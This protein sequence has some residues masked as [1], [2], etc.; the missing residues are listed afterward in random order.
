MRL[1]L[2]LV[3]MF[4]MKMCES[5]ILN[6]SSD[7]S[8]N[9]GLV[10]PKPLVSH[11]RCDACRYIALVI[12]SNLRTADARLD[13]VEE[14]NE[15]EIEVI[16]GDICS[17]SNYRSVELIKLDDHL[18]LAFPQLE[19]WEKGSTVSTQKDWT[20]RVS[21]HCRY[22]L[23]KM[24]GIELYDL[25]LRAG[26]RNPLAWI[27]FMCEGEGVFSDCTQEDDANDWPWEVHTHTGNKKKE[28]SSSV[29]ED[30][31]A[32]SRPEYL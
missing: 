2:C 9:S 1:L 20:E 21:S 8:N 10:L 12:D 19:T 3:C 13:G 15:D 24:R 4:V 23:D 27:E 22:M 29:L 25:W 30:K 11:P 5:W 16:A 31:M 17:K 32:N 14:L 26:H 7:M 6:S 28:S 18:R